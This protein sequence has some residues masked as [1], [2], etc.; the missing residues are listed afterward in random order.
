MSVCWTDLLDCWDLKENIFVYEDDCEWAGDD[1]QIV[2]LD[3]TIDFALL[4]RLCTTLLHGIWQQGILIANQIYRYSTSC[5]TFIFVLNIF[6][7]NIIKCLD[8]EDQG[9]RN[10]VGARERV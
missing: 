5:K 4:P 2:F 7:A 3:F 1:F 8:I 9:G 6:F 10:A